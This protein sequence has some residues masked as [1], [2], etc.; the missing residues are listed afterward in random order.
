MLMLTPIR[1]LMPTP[2]PTVT[3]MQMQMQMQMPTEA[4]M[5]AD[6]CR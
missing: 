1:T 3:Q 4:S 5:T 2:T 6:S